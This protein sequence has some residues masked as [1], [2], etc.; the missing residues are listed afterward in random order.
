MRVLS[1][2]ASS[3]RRAVPPLGAQF[4]G[5][6]VLHV[7]QRGGVSEEANHCHGKLVL[8]ARQWDLLPS[9]PNEEDA[10]TFLSHEVRLLGQLNQPQRLT[11]W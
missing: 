1:H 6:R 4:R 3:T 2:A 11:Y 9:C 10:Q 5:A 8:K 7:L